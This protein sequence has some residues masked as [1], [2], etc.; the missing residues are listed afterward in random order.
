MSSMN[1]GY[2]RVSTPD[3]SLDLQLD[4][5]TQKGDCIKIYQEVATGAKT[6]RPELQAMLDMLRP[7]DTVVVYKIDRISRS[8]KHLIE[9]MDYF[10]ANN[11]NFVSLNDNIDTRSATGKLIFR[12]FAVLAEY[13]RDLLRERTNA[14]LAAARARGRKGGRPK[15]DKK[16]IQ[17]ALTLYDSR[18]YSLKEI[19]AATGISIPTIYKYLAERDK[20][21]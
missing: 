20:Q 10:E 4:A 21:K 13:E 9:L 14:G 11:I 16:A 12:V 19:H 18:D 6:D 2:A 5:L 1:V 8:T 15:V 3:Q 17:R 7:G